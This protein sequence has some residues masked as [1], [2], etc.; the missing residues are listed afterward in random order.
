MF[1][2]GMP[3]LLLILVV[4]LLIF[5]P[6]RLPELARSIGKG[7]AEFR[8]AS[9]ELRDQVMNPPEPPPPPRT[10]PGPAIAPPVA[11]SPATPSAP[12]DAVPAGPTT[13]EVASTST[14]ST[15]LDSPTGG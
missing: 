5:G 3:E 7:L 2:I 4:A 1:G 12:P 15:P 6:N 10:A 11:S 9:N 14:H 13:T 8:R